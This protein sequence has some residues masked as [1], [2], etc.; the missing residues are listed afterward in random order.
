MAVW[1]SLVVTV[2]WLL[3]YHHKAKSIKLTSPNGKNHRNKKRERRW[4]IDDWW[5]RYSLD[6]STLDW[7][8]HF[9]Y[10][11]A[12]PTKVRRQGR[13]MSPMWS[14]AYFLIIRLDFIYGPLP[15]L[16]Q[17]PIS[18]ISSQS[19]LE[20]LNQSADDQLFNSNPFIRVI[21]INLFSFSLSLD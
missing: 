1:S 19:S 12:T 15:P 17:H 18:Q 14:L 10:T 5:T 2:G 7:C 3:C 13:F 4:F 9:D 11:R 20:Q 8:Y 6:N 21:W 16:V